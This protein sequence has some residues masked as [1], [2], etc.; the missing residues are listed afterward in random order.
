MA[1]LDVAETMM[2]SATSGCPEVD[3]DGL[4]GG[5]VGGGATHVGGLP[6]DLDHRRSRQIEGRCARGFI[7]LHR[8]NQKRGTFLN[9][10]L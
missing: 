4:G 7:C 1:E 3:P 8:I 10:I 6:P 2:W 5:V 9:K